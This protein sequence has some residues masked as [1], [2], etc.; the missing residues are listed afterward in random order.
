MSKGMFSD[1][2]GL[3]RRDL[4]VVAGTA[5]ATLSVYSSVARAASGD[6]TLVIDEVKPGEDV[7]AYVSRSKG[8]FDQTTYR[9]V[10]GC[11][12]AFKEGDQTIGVAAENETSRT[13]AR[14]LLANTKIGDLFDHPLLEDELQRLIW[15]TTDKTQHEKVKDWTMG[16]LKE[17][18]LT[19]SEEEI[20]G[21]MNGLTSDTIG[22]VPKLMSNEE[23]ITVSQ[24]IFNVMPGTKLGAKGYMGARIQP[25]S[26]TDH[27][28]DIMWQVFD[29]FSYATG[30]IVIGTNPVDSTVASVV[31]V[32]RALKDVV[33]TFKLG[34]VIPWCV[35]AHID[36]QAEVNESYPG[37]VATVFQSLAGTDDC[38]KIFDIT[39]DKIVK[40]ARAKAG[41]RYGLYF[42]TG[43]GSEFTN[44]VANGV[45]MMVLE[46]RKYGF[47]RAIGLELAK[48]QPSG[49]WLHVNDVAGFIGPEVFKSREQLVRCCLEDMV[50]GKLHGLTIGLDICTTLHMTVSLDD[51]DWCQDQIMPANPAY[52]I[53]LPTKNDPMLSYLTTAFQDHV[54]VR[55]KFGFKVN[56]AMWD[57]YKRIGIVGNDNTYTSNYG[58]PLWVYYQYRLAKGDKRAKDAVYAEGRQMMTE[59]EARGVDLAT[60]HGEKLWDL[61][62]ALA[63]KVRG[64]YDDAKLSL[65][66]ELTPEF[67]A[68]VPDAV[69]VR[70][71][72]KDRND[73]IAHPTTG[74]TLSPESM[75]EIE[76]IR[77]SW[78]ADMPKGQIVISDG[79]NAKAIMDDG[80]L[81]PY[82]EEMR[83]LLG[84]AGVTVSDKNIV[85]TSGRVRAGYRIGEMLFADADPNSFRGI[86]HIIGERP[87]TMHHAYSVYI[88]VAKGKRWAEKDIDHD[89]TKLVS[90]VA[91]TALAPKEAA[92]ETL[93][94]IREIIG[95]DVN[96]SRRYG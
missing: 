62:P 47:S 52:L 14:A 84:D 79:L 82:L 78:K 60:G 68:A 6:S 2:C 16:Q 90:N 18:L 4:L 57:F 54:R 17:F 43:Q 12:N 66:A 7:F 65:W 15:Q 77:A 20:K 89:M 10:L 38:N 40:Y 9:Q 95:K 48:V 45:D 85:V 58:D 36:V 3:S 27:P 55:E 19:A 35:L 94:I 71:L 44:G 73:Y 21:V 88:T 91:D 25:N 53:A 83:R 93:T 86:L 75:K 22:F 31:T 61:N 23:L 42:E 8:A 50:M 34:D 80:H 46:S 39:N 87:G 49:A 56:D 32:E 13:N 5:A 26:P 74:E 64:L 30:D 67:I 72:S 28:D 70:T 69:P 59:V 11:A 24:K 63:T 33:D 29:A 41:E 37:T 81:A 96:G 76:R 1:Q 51:L 92:K